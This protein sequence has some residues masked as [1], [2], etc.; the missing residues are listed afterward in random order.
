WQLEARD[1]WIGWSLEARCQ[2]LH[3]VIAN[4]RFLILPH[5]RAANLASHALGLALKRVRA[6]WQERYGYEPLLVETFADTERFRGTCYRA[7][8]WVLVGVTA[9]RGRQDAQHAQAL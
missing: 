6:D 1:R 3:R 9:G 8:N 7:A 4:S 2:H 5:L